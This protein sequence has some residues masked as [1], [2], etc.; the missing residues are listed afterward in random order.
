MTAARDTVYIDEAGGFYLAF[1]FSKELAA[2]AKQRCCS[3]ILD[4]IID[5]G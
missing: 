2:S 4:S 5:Q 3:I 1:N